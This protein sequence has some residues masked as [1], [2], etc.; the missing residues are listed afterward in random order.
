MLF[1]N[2]NDHSNRVAAAMNGPLNQKIGNDREVRLPRVKN[3]SL[4]SKEVSQNDPGQNQNAE[5]EER[6]KRQSESNEIFIQKNLKNMN[7]IVGPWFYAERGS[8]SEN[9]NE[10]SKQGKFFLALARAGLLD[11][12]NAQVPLDKQSAIGLLKEVA[13]EDPENS[14]P[15][16]FLSVIHEADG[17]LAEAAYFRVRAEKSLRFDS[18][19]NDFISAIFKT[20]DSPGSL[21]Q[22]YSLW[23]TT[24]IPHYKEIQKL[25]KVHKSEIL[26]EQLIAK[27]LDPDNNFP[28]VN[29][30]PVEYAFG[31]ASLKE[32]G[33]R[34]NLPNLQ[35]LIKI[36]K[37]IVP[38][39]SFA[40][41]EL[42]K[43]CDLSVFRP[44]TN[45]IME[46]FDSAN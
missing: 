42:E 41:L 31:V 45:A 8:Y 3:S 46:Y 7:S 44:A 9:L 33:K 4:R 6:I 5:C 2:I 38:Y 18:Y 11:G 24:P 28:D 26:A 30:S 37:S 39:D 23:A 40:Y 17:N 34:H 21:F 19:L 32:L 16:V 27:A 25:I 13:A 14:A 36:K 43:T 22:A 10:V 20:I 1:F 35:N 29:W 15:F 12:L